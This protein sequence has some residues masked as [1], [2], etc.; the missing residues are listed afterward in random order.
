MRCQAIAER[1]LPRDVL[2]GRN[3]LHQVLIRCVRFSVRNLPARFLEEHGG[4]STPGATQGDTCRRRTWKRS[5]ERV[6]F[7]PTTTRVKISA[8]SL[9][10]TAL[11][12]RSYDA[13]N[14]QKHASSCATTRPCERHGRAS[15]QSG[16]T[17]APGSA[18]LDVKS[19]N[20][21]SRRAS[22]EPRSAFDRFESLRADISFGR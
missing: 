10:E 1:A 22:K 14:R 13:A 7:L 21:S 18:S 19:E 6:F 17:I 20:S 8:T 11:S 4:I 16:R 15:K 2:H 5:N 9:L 3:A 12:T